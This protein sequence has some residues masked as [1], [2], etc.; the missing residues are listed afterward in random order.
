M[1]SENRL[2]SKQITK[3]ILEKFTLKNLAKLSS[4]FDAPKAK[5]PSHEP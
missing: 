3:C 2:N 5:G 4:K 1:M